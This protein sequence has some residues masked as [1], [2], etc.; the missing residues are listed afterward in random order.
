MTEH[1]LRQGAQALPA[2]HTHYRHHRSVYACHEGDAFGGPSSVYRSRPTPDRNDAR[3]LPI[4][5]DRIIAF[6]RRTVG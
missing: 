1:G 6:F 2:P 5:Q 3:A 4:T